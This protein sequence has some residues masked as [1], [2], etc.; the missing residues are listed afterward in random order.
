MHDQSNMGHSSKKNISNAKRTLI[1]INS[2][3]ELIGKKRIGE[4]AEMEEV[5]KWRRIG[6]GLEVDWRRRGCQGGAEVDEKEMEM[7]VSVMMTVWFIFCLAIVTHSF[8]FIIVFENDNDNRIEK[9]GGEVFPHEIWI[10][11]V[12]L[13]GR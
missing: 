1:A 13:S 9:R 12:N 2:D 4:G 8:T 5:W 3:A 7:M 10:K 6:E 11:V